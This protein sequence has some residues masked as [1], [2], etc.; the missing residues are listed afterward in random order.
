MFVANCKT[1]QI[2]PCN[3]H[4]ATFC[5]SIARH[6]EY[7]I[8]MDNA[9]NLWGLI[10]CE[11]NM[12]FPHFYK[13]NNLD[14]KSCETRAQIGNQEIRILVLFFFFHLVTVYLEKSLQFFRSNKSL[15]CFGQDYFQG[16]VQL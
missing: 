6:R 11:V 7:H 15:D 2:G 13:W 14:F 1:L 10:G 12:G 9:P 5:K 8:E 4:V 3:M 16:P